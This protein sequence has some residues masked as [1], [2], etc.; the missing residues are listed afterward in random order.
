MNA[1]TRMARIRRLEEITPPTLALMTDRERGEY[2]LGH[3]CK[4]LLS[5]KEHKEFAALVPDERNHERCAEL[6]NRGLHRLGEF[7]GDADAP[8]L[9]ALPSTVRRWA[10][11]WAERAEH[12][13]SPL[14]YL[15]H[16]P[17]A[18][19]PTPEQAAALRTAIRKIMGGAQ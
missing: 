2:M 12:W 10:D 7:F 3:C 1:R 15:D 8:P 4:R 13:E 17:T 18:P 14:L 16:D 6:L 5:P 9:M 11:R 19:L